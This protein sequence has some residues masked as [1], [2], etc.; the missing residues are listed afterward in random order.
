MLEAARA[1]DRLGNVALMADALCLNRRTVMT[2]DSPEQGNPPKIELL[3]RA[4]ARSGDDPSLRARLAGTLAHEFLYTGDVE[5]RAAFIALARRDLERVADPI[6]RWQMGTPLRMATAL[7]NDRQEWQQLDDEFA[8]VAKAAETSGDDYEFGLALVGLFYS[9]LA[10]GRPSRDEVLARLDPVLARYPHPFLWDVAMPLWIIAALVDGRTADAETLADVLER[11]SRQHDNV[12]EMQVYVSSARVEATRERSGLEPVIEFLKAMPL[13]P[14]DR[15][16]PTA[17][18]GITALALAEA[19]RM[20]E[21]RAMIDEV[22]ANGFRDV[23]DD[24]ALAVVECTW[25][26]AAALTGHVAACEAL[27]ERMVPRS[28]Q[29]ALTGGWYLGS[30]ARYLGLFASVLGRPGEAEEWFRQA[31]VDHIAMR[32]PPWLARG[33]LD[34]AEALCRRGEVGRSEELARQA[35]IA[36]GDLDLGASRSRAEKLLVTP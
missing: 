33:R 16:K 26:E 31:E 15:S 3:E 36:I 18:P 27:Y 19:G 5:R 32:T 8:L 25:A 21:A 10:L 34:W 7:N 28:N 24:A 29:H 17:I 4:L 2:A 9:S 20:Q 23:L 22:C 13:R 12:R 30:M 6:E 14:S 1:A 35:L 11:E